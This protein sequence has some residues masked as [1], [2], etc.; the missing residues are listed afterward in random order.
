[1]VGD[2]AFVLG[3]IPRAIASGFA[4]FWDTLGVQSRRR[5]LLALLGGAAV[6]LLLF[7]VVPALPC[8]VPGGERCP[9]EDDAAEIVPA[10]TLAYAH[11]NADPDTDQYEGAAEL[12]ERVPKLS[13]QVV[14]RL[15][16]Q[17]PGPRGAPPSFAR[18]IEPWFGGEAAVAVLPKG[19]ASEQVRLLEASDSEGALAFAEEISSGAPTVEEYQG[20]DVRVDDRGLATALVAGFLVIAD[21][22]SAVRAIV[23]VG[24]GEEARSLAADEIATEIRDRL[25]D[26]RIAEVYLSGDGVADYVAER[27]ASLSTLE[28][29]VNARA[30]GGSAMALIA[31]S[32]DLEFAIRSSLDPER[33]RAQPGFFGALP[34]FEP[35]LAEKLDDDTLGYVG[36]GDPERAVKRLLTQASADAPGIAAGF[37]DLSDELRDLGKVD[38]EKDLLPSLGGE[39]AFSLQ[40]GRLQRGEGP[41]GRDAAPVPGIESGPAP[42]A[43]APVPFLSALVDG[44]DTEGAKDALARLQGPI[45]EALRQ[46]STQAPVFNREEVEGVIA[47]SLRISPTVNLTY[48]LLDSLLVVATDPQGVAEVAAEEGGLSDSDRFELVT[49]ELTDEDPSLLVYLNLAELVRLGELE[50]LSESPAYAEFAEEL[51]RM[52]ALGLAVRSS[53]AELDTDARV[54]VAAAPEEPE[55]APQ[56]PAPTEPAS[57]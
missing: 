12:A 1:M 38:I 33:S 40:P 20:A 28:P 6:A 3:R 36:I 15:L 57:D 42:S 30:T 14:G 41:S 19:R 46:S 39:A 54:T 34:G 52:L 43:G 4:G 47:Q 31:G 7:V 9:P 29:F 53:E 10:E 22:E 16:S 23:D 37:A 8:Q 44:V 27:G 24:A 17:L 55:E 51:R 5:L 56:A 26:H 21:S 18:D 50:G 2:V 49:E 25:P 35:T 32:G 48:A 45:A 13:Q 11:L